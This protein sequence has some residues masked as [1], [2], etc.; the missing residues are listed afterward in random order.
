M[1]WSVETLRPRQR[2]FERHT[3]VESDWD[4]RT[5][6]MVNIVHAG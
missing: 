4:E 3:E 6:K 5:R 2:A 1:Y